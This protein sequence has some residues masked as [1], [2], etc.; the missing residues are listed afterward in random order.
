M[1]EDA[2]ATLAAL[3]HDWADAW[4]T[5]NVAVCQRLLAYD[6]MEVSACGRLVSKGEWIAAIELN[7][8]RTIDWGDVR[9]RLFGRFAVVHS[10][11][12][13]TNN[14]KGQEHRA[15]YMATDIWTCHGEEWQVVSRQLTRV[16]AA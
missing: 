9:I 12:H 8:P 11:L 16:R 5:G 2:Y 1:R 13:L 6:F 4:L 15:E 7:R 10:R 14:A 3:E